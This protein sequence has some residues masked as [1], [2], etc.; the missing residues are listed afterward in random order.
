MADDRL[1]VALD[2]STMEQM[3]DIVDTLGDA[4]SFYKVGMELFRNY[5]KYGRDMRN[6]IRNRNTTVASV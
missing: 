6:I 2:V 3:K 5:F 4:V 1:I